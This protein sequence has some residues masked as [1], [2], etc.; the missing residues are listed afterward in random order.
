MQNRHNSTLPEP[1]E[2]K[3]CMRG[4]FDM[5]DSILMVPGSKHGL[6]SSCLTFLL[7]IFYVVYSSGWGGGVGGLKYNSKFRSFEWQST[8]RSESP[9]IQVFGAL[10]VFWTPMSECRF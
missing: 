2:L 6:K 10:D 3:I 4:V 8:F 1:N 7:F 5:P 9:K